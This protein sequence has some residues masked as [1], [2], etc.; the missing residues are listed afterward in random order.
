MRVGTVFNAGAC[1]CGGTWKRNCEAVT[2]SVAF[3]DT[4]SIKEEEGVGADPPR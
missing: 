4:S 2:I 3:G 1:V